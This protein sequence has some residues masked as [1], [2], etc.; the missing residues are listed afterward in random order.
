MAKECKKDDLQ[1]IPECARDFIKLVVRKMRYRKKVRA[2]VQA[3]LVSHFEDELKN[4]K[5]DEEK[6]QKAQRLIEDFGDAKLLGILLRRAKKRC[7]PLWRTIVARTFQTIGVLILLFIAYTGWFLTG[8]PTLSVDYLEIINQKNKPELSEQDNAWPDYEKAIELFVPLDEEMEKMEA[9]RNMGST[10]VGFGEL[11]RQDQE[12]IEHWVTD[13]NSAWQR[14]TEASNKRY[15]YLQRHYGEK[16]KEKWLLSILLPELKPLRG[17]TL[18]GIWHSRINLDNGRVNQALDDCLV[19]IRTGRFWQL[20]KATIIEQLLGQALSNYGHNEISYILSKHRLEAG[21]L[22]HIQQPLL[23]IYRD[24]YPMINLET[25]KL[26]FM[27]VVQHIFTNGGLGGGHLIPQRFEDMANNTDFFGNGSSGNGDKTDA[28]KTLL[29]TASAMYHARRDKTVEK[30]NEVYDYLSR[31]SK[32]TP[33]HRHI[34]DFNSDQF[35]KSIPRYRY[36]LASMFMPAFGRAF[37]RNYQGVILHEATITVLAIER[38]KLEKGKYPDSLEQLKTE[39]Y[40]NSLPMDPYS[41]K[42]LVYRRTADNFTLYSISQNFTD[43]GGQVYR[44]KEGKV[45]LW[46]DEADA[47]FWPVPK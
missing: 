6:Q 24:G 2:D 23:D 42:P 9:L 16:N 7:R 31:L 11:N 46:A 20:S 14:F 17:L 10:H 35:E 19:I 40:I 36:L 8:K 21:E 5:T 33:Y 41:D 3:E 30:I 18:S 44:D 45:R 28:A 34:N 47:V 4:C 26:M 38:Y 22:K 12:K 39:G 13:N 25:E 32:M 1:S 37:E 27:D 29:F 15:C 43:D